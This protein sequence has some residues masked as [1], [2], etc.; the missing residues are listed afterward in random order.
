MEGLE[1]VFAVDIVE[2]ITEVNPRLI[3][4]VSWIVWLID[5]V[6]GAV[7]LLESSQSWHFWHL[8]STQ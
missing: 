5:E 3:S 4:V 8:K 1:F 7:L 2:T 6:S